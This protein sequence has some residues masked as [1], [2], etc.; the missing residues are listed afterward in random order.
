MKIVKFSFF[1]RMHLRNIGQNN[2]QIKTLDK[3]TVNFMFLSYDH[4]KI[5]Q[6][7]FYLPVTD[8]K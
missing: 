4:S 7:Q 2:T 3:E 5:L 6:E 1:I 8:G